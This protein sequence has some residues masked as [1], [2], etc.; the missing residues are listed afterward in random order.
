MMKKKSILYIRIGS[1]DIFG[2]SSWPCAQPSAC[3]GW[4]NVK[5]VTGLHQFRFR[6]F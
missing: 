3:Q 5:R 2:A 6:H 4:K 1:S